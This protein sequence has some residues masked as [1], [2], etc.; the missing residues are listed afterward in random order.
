MK[1]FTVKLTDEERAGLEAHRVALGLRAH[2]DVIRH[3][4]AQP[5]ATPFG[6]ASFADLQAASG[7]RAM[8]KVVEREGVLSTTPPSEKPFKSRLK[9]EWKA[10]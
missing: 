3:W 2:T 9:G 1:L 4:I 10:P 8:R 5:A 7:M 6:E